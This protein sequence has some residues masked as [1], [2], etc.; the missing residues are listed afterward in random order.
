MAEGRMAALSLEHP[1]ALPTRRMP[2]PATSCSLPWRAPS[3]SSISATKGGEVD[4]LKRGFCDWVYAYTGFPGNRALVSHG[5][6]PFTRLDAEEFKR[7]SSRWKTAFSQQ[8][9]MF[10]MD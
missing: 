6:Q 9:N 7:L 2:R 8:L 4:A 5:A 10:D 3:S 1:E